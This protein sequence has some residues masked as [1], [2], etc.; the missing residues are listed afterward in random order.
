MTATIKICPQ[1]PSHIADQ[2]TGEWARDV[3][4]LWAAG[5]DDGSAAAE[6]YFAPLAQAILQSIPYTRGYTVPGE[7]EGNREPGDEARAA[8]AAYALGYTLP[9]TIRAPD[10]DCAH[11]RPRGHGCSY[12]CGW[13]EGY[14][15]GRRKAVA[16]VGLPDLATEYALLDGCN[17]ARI[18]HAS[19]P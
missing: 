7:V 16:A 5:K 13:R 1:L 19:A 14:G 10:F 6:T 8:A 17:A 2:L 9:D 3:G 18:A 15:I 4:V 11:Q 12:H